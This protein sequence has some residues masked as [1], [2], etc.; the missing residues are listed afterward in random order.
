MKGLRKHFRLKD[1]EESH[2]H[3]F[4][5]N[6]E[7]IGFEALK[8][9]PLQAAVIFQFPESGFDALS[10]VVKTIKCFGGEFKIAR[11]GVITG[12]SLQSAVLLLP[13]YPADDND[14]GRDTVFHGNL[15]QIRDGDTFRGVNNP[16]GF[17]PCR[18]SEEFFPVFHRIECRGG[19]ESVP[20]GKLFQKKQVP[21]RHVC[22]VG[23]DNFNGKTERYQSPD[24]FLKKVLRIG[25]ARK[26]FRVNE[27]LSDKGCRKLKTG[28]SLI[29]LIVSGFGPLLPGGGGLKGGDIN[30]R[31]HLSAGTQ[32]ISLSRCLIKIRAAKKNLDQVRSG[33]SCRNHLIIL[34][35]IIG[36]K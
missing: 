25:A 21:R 10:F 22:A 27:K 17:F 15:S 7:F 8:R 33:T 30:V 3:D 28:L 24:G 1:F 26:Q 14:P 6:P 20:E 18:L 5:H 4:A 16:G 34:L 19:S 12:V 23:P 9:Q 32:Q 35:N 11:N 31:N 36:I 13:V 2:R 29:F